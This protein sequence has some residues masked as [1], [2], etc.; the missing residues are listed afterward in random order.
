MLELG[1]NYCVHTRGKKASRSQRL[2]QRVHDIKRV[3]SCSEV[4]ARMENLESCF[5]GTR[6]GRWLRGGYYNDDETGDT[7]DNDESDLNVVKG[8]RQGHRL[9]GNVSTVGSVDIVWRSA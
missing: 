1:S 3:S 2:T 7:R 9:Q 5:E 4:L 8:Q 6:Q